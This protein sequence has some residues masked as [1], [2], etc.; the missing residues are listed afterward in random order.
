[1]DKA[2]TFLVAPD[3]PPSQTLDWYRLNIVLQQALQ[4]SVHL[5]LTTGFDAYHQAL[6][7]LPS[8]VYVGA[9]DTAKMIRQYHY[10]PLARPESASDEV[11]IFTDANSPIFYLKDINKSTHFVC[12]IDIDVERVG[13]ILLEPDEIV[14]KEVDWRSMDSYQSVIRHVLGHKN[15]VGIIRANNFRS[16]SPNLRRRCRTVITSS[17]SVLFHT[18]LLSPKC[19]AYKEDFAKALKQLNQH[20]EIL[21]NI[22]LRSFKPMSETVAHFICDVVDTLS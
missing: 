8:L 5:K 22:G 21:N 3:F 17:L 9:Y 16:L 1:M 6:E 20:P 11:V 7:A 12:Q 13:R 14:K 10:L 4:Q 19:S 2:F 18:L 15:S